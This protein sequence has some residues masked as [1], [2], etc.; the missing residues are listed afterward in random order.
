MNN[1]IVTTVGSISEWLQC[2]QVRATAFLP[3]EPYHEEFDNK[4]FELVTH[5][6]AVYMNTPAA[7]MR[8][9]F[10]SP[11]HGGT[12]HWGRLAMMPNIQSKVRL[13]TLNAIADYAEEYSQIRGF[14]RIIGEV[15]DKR[16]MK[17]WNRRGFSLTGEQPV[18]YGER[19]FWPMAKQKIRAAYSPLEKDTVD[20]GKD[21]INRGY[22]K[23]P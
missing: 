11:D 8:L 15:S 22:R 7:C 19:Q 2:Q 3:T 17:F 12:I 21:D 10:I 20:T 18:D 16:L 5:L 14:N 6:L 9:R 13:A 23:L 1:I 4:D